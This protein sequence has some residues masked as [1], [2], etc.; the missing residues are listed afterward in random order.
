MVQVC[1][2]VELLNLSVQRPR[3][4]SRRRHVENG[5]PQRYE[6]DNTPNLAIHQYF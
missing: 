6:T 1:Q 4:T 5:P 3:I 2:T